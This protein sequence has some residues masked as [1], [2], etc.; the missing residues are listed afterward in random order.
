M[1]Y[2]LFDKP[3]Q[4]LL[5]AASVHG[6]RILGNTPA[7]AKAAGAEVA[8]MPAWLQAAHERVASKAAG[9][10]LG[11]ERAG[12]ESGRRRSL[13]MRTGRLESTR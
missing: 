6:Q 5:E 12:S 7:L 13:I 9:R 4:A 3:S 1:T 2:T 11:R 8:R 10:D